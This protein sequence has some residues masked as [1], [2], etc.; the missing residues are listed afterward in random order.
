[1]KPAIA[2]SLSPRRALGGVGLRDR[3]EHHIPALQEQ[4]VEDLVLGGEVVVDEPVGDAGLVGDIRDAA[5]V[6][7]LPREHPHRG[8][9]DHAA[10][11]DRAL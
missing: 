9:E 5:G 6:E 8:V 10:L 11:V 3:G 7:P 4:R 2:A 1:M